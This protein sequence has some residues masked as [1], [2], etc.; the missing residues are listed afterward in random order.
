MDFNYTLFGLSLLPFVL[1]IVKLAQSFGLADFAADW[2]RAVLLG[3]AALIAL[4][5]SA[6]TAAWPAFGTY[7]P[8]VLTVL[9]VILTAKGFLPEVRA[10]VMKLQGGQVKDPDSAVGFVSE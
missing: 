8:Q 1:G 5:E 2:L 4:N 10:V 7:G 3:L 6:I 9:G